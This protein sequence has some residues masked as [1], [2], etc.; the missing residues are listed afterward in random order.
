MFCICIDIKLDVIFGVGTCYGP[1][2]LVFDP[3][4]CKGLSSPYSHRPVNLV[5]LQWVLGL[6]P[7]CGVDCN[8]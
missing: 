3:R 2:G 7:E 4:G 1:D 5:S 8:C 6:F